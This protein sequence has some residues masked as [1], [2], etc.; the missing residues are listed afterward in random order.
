M[1]ST[2]LKFG[3]FEDEDTISSPDVAAAVET[4]AKQEGAETRGAIFIR[5]EVVVNVG[6]NG[7]EK[8]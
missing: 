3:L 7:G 1:S 8:L 2:Q 4:L 6:K 5:P